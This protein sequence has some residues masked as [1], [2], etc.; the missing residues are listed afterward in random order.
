MDQQSLE[1]VDKVSVAS[2]WS[3][4]DARIASLHT[5]RSMVRHGS[6]FHSYL[7][8]WAVFLPGVLLRELL[9]STPSSA[10]QRIWD[11]TPS[12]GF[13]RTPASSP[14]RWTPAQPSLR[15][16]CWLLRSCEPF[17]V[18]VGRSSAPGWSRVNPGHKSVCQAPLL[19]HFGQATILRRLGS[20]TDASSYL[21]LRWPWRPASR[22]ASGRFWRDLVFFPRE[23]IDDRS[24]PRGRCCSRFTRGWELRPTSVLKL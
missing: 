11:L 16:D 14:L 21:R 3:W 9:S 13:L 6:V 23:P 24:L 15:A 20:V 7:G 12:I 8:W 22:D 4:R 2:L 10:R 19:S 17:C 1:F 5:L 18:V